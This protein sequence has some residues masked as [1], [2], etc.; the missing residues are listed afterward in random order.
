[1]AKDSFSLLDWLRKMGMDKDAD[2]LR[3]SVQML[4]QML[5]EA[6]ATEKIGAGA[7]ERTPARVT[8]RNGA[9]E[10]EWD[11]RVGTVNLSI[12]KL[13]QGSFFPSLL[14]PRRRT[15][16][17][18]VAV[19]QEA[20]VHG[21]STRK[22]DELVQAL[23]MTGISRS[24]VSRLCAELDAEVERFRNRRLDGEYPYMWLD[25]TFLKVREDGRVQSMAMVIAVG[26]NESGERR[27]L[28]YD[29]GPSED[30]AFWLEFLRSL[31]ARGLK[32]VRLVISDSHEGLKNAIQAVLQGAAWQRCRVHFVRNVFAHVPKSAQQMVA[33]SIKTVFI[34]QDQQSARVQLGHVAAGLEKRFPRAAEILLEA[35]EDVLAFMAF[36]SE[37]WRQ[38]YSTNPLERLNKEVKRRTDVVGIFPN[39]G[40]VMR[41]AGAVLM[42]Q[43]DEWA[44][45]KRYFSQQSMAKLKNQDAMMR[46]PDLML[47]QAS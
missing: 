6:E 7:Y 27:I 26:V 21:V 46:Q 18:L 16:K 14:E 19:V 38:I 36:P 40:A 25:A 5:I 4:A 1:M 43:D 42:E 17:A 24:A 44:V 29:L 47:A 41:L 13:R 10:R 37:H 15:E 22:V 33:A 20:Y 8:Y 28:G 23:G 32:G 35:E 31:V 45:G 30:G 3:E 11:T 2:F 39:Y 12:P 9:R 34:Q